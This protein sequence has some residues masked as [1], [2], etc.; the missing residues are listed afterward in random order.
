[1]AC[2]LFR[3]LPG[4][5]VAGS[6]RGDI[7]FGAADRSRAAAQQTAAPSRM[8]GSRAAFLTGI[9]TLERGRIP[10]KGISPGWAAAVP[11]ELAVL[12]RDASAQAADVSL[13]PRCRGGT[14]LGRPAEGG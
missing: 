4:L 14:C 3:P 1:V 9:L 6:A 5:F 7:C 8:L 11:T 12:A 13:L 2:S 10:R